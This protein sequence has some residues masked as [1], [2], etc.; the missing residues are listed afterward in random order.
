MRYRFLISLFVLFAFVE[1]VH[2]QKDATAEINKIKLSNK[3]I[4]ATGTSMK[5]QE[6]ASE[7]GKLLLAD[8][9]EKWLKDNAKDDVAGYV[10]KSKENASVIETQRGKLFRSFV[11]V[12][13]SDILPYYKDEEVITDTSH[14]ESTS[15]VVDTSQCEYVKPASPSAPF[16]TNKTAVENKSLSSVSMITEEETKMLE[17]YNTKTFNQY[18]DRLNKAGHLKSYGI[19]KVWPMQ[20]TVYVFFIAPDRVVNDH[21][22]LTDGKAVDLSTGSSVNIQSIKEKYN[23]GSYIWFTLK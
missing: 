18:L 10:T 3:Y 13:K 11:Y 5:S 21:M 8:E 17:V 2:S 9:I 14:S 22:R 12:K 7:Y 19:Q 23:Q 15:Q 16:V 20:G 6:E 1:A 4:S